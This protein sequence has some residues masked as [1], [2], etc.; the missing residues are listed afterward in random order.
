MIDPA[1]KG[2]LRAAYASGRLLPFIGAGVSMSVQWTT[3]SG[4]VRRG[5]S[6]REL[7]DR[8]AI[9]LGF[10]QPDLLR[11]RGEDLQIL[12][13]FRAKH[14]D[15]LAPLTNWLVQN[16]DAPD[17]ALRASPILKALA[18]LEKCRIFYTTNFDSFL[19]RSFKLHGRQTVV[20]ATEEE[21]GQAVSVLRE[22]DGS[23]EVIKFHGD[24]DHPDAM[25]VSEQDYRERL[26]LITTMDDRLKSDLLGRLVLFVGYSFRDWN[27]SYLY[28]VLN[29]LH[30]HLPESATGRRGYITVPDPSDFERRLFN[31][32]RIGVIPIAS[33][34]D[35]TSE[36]AAVIETI[37]EGSSA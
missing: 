12:E 23:C 14:G 25:V 27:V 19:E 33:G 17:T 36:V 10:Q 1:S 15:R 35:L 30:G 34:P 5:P 13:Y 29:R 8:A 32:R 3:A 24:L 22:D 9:M 18:D 20:V 26:Q 16:L 4:D 6:W 28:H 7:V 11:V 21:I 37:T 2:E 31:A